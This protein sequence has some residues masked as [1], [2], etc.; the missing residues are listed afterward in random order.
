MILDPDGTEY[1]WFVGYGP[2]PEK[3]EARLEK[4]LS[5][6]DTFK[7]LSSAY[8]KNPKDVAVVFGLAR[9][10]ADRYDEAKAEE[11][12]KEVISLDPEGK[13]G[14]YT[15]EYIKITAPYTENAEFSLGTM[16]IY[17]QKPD[18]GLLKAFIQKYPNSKL[19]REAY[20]YMAGYYSY[21]APKEE[22]TKFFEEYTAKYPDDP[23]ALDMWLARIVKDKDPLAKGAALAEKIQELTRET[24]I[25][26]MNQDMADLYVLQ[27]DRERAEEVY[28]KE[29]MEGRVSMFAYNLIGYANFWLKNQANQES[30][31]AKAETALKLQP[32]NSY[33]LQQVASAYVQTGK[34]DKALAIFGPEYAKKNSGDASALYSYARFWTSQGKNMDSAL[35][36][37]KKAVDLRPD[38]SYI[39]STLSDI[40]LKMKNYAEALT[41]AQKAFD[42]SEGA[43][44]ARMKSKLDSIKKAQA[45]E[46][47]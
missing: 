45:E 40:Y 9:K 15:L 1:D 27:N 44:K 46:K 6:V 7:A 30:A 43:A 38:A 13:A 14:T 39:W 2:P 42:L 37:A 41:A 3:F 26:D 22:A 16:K 12:Y 11:K 24:P 47:K 5:G 32:D 34:E 17:G 35:E 10:Y 36:A 25:P 19:V 23:R 4:S 8:A 21:S 31:V 29:F 18:P 28:G 20:R 33:I